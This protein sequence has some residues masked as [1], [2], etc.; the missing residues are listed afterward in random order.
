MIWRSDRFQ[1]RKNMSM[2]DVLKNSNKVLSCEEQGRLFTQVQ[3]DKNLCKQFMDRIIE[4][5]LVIVSQQ[6]GLQIPC[7]NTKTTYRSCVTFRDVV[8]GI[9]NIVDYNTKAAA[10]HFLTVY[11]RDTLY[12]NLLSTTDQIE[13]EKSFIAMHNICVFYLQMITGRINHVY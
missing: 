7:D 9:K 13:A 3:M 12:P 5:S 11:W 6:I 4:S 2:A 8:T 1:T 10:L